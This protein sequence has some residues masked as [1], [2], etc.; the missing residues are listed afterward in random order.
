VFP[1]RYEHIYIIKSS[2]IPVKVY[3][4]LQ[5]N[6]MPRNPHCQDNRLTDSGEVVNLSPATLYNLQRHF[7]LFLLWYLLLLEAE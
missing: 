4:G 7:L 2:A 3:G 1:I 5:G 6:E